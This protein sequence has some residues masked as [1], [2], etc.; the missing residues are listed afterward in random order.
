M[1]SNHQKIGMGKLESKGG[2]PSLPK[3]FCI[4]KTFCK[5]KNFDNEIFLNIFQILMS[6][7]ESSVTKKKRG[8]AYKYV[9]TLI[10]TK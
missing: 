4:P 10:I 2:K 8:F 7:S 6:N 3:A 5:K 1:E 9:C